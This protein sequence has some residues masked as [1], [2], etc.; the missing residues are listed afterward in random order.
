[1][2]ERTDGP[3][4]DSPAI[5]A[6][7]G[8]LFSIF[9][10]VLVDFLGFGLIIPLLPFYVPDYAENPMKVALIFSIYSVCQFVG[11]PILGSLSDRYGRRPVLIFSQIGSAAGY[12]LLGVASMPG[13]FDPQT[14]LMLVYLSRVIDGFTG[15]NVA[16]AQAYI[17]DVTTSENRAKGMGMLGAAFGIGF[18]LGPFLGGVLGAYNVSWPAYAAALLATLAAVT[19]FFKLPESHTN[20]S[21]TARSQHW[22]SPKRV[23]PVLKKP[24]VGQLLLIA[25]V[26]MAAFVIMEATVGLF[27]AKIWEIEDQKT[28]AR[29][30]GWFF[31]YVGLIIVIVQGGLIG[32]LTTRFGEWRLAIAGA[33]FVAVGMGFYISAGWWPTILM[34]ALAGATNAIGRSLQGP[35]LSSLISKYSDPR[36]QG[37]VFGLYHGLSSMARVIGPLLAGLTYP[38]LHNT[39]QYWTAGFIVLIVAAWT[40]IVR[41]QAHA[42]AGDTINNQSVAQAAVAEIE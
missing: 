1:M 14:R 23:L 32:R 21:T 12:V 39:G 17:S 8:A 19:T 35:T 15:G 9:L 25:F 29:L 36:E 10:I 22:L 3:L 4:G 24:I 31:G 28:A 42:P 41:A 11:A 6:P 7:K 34:I 5:Q 16:T 18:C 26:S 13:W 30:T 38:Y 20:R 27:L 2:S 37:V 33:L 40:V